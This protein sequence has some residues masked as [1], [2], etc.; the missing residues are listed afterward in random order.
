M[1]TRDSIIS[2]AIKLIEEIHVKEGGNPWTD[3]FRD[4]VT[5]AAMRQ[6]HIFDI[7]QAIHEELKLFDPEHVD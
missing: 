5:K 2:D 1:I 3:E 6:R 4:K 7:K